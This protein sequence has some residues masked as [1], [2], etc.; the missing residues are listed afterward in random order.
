MDPV[1]LD[2][3]TADVT[4]D[5]P[6]VTFTATLSQVAQGDVTVVTDQ[7]NITILDGQTTGTLV[8][9]TQDSDVYLDASSLTATITG[10]TGPAG[11]TF[12]NLNIAT[13]TA[14]A[15][16]TDTLDLV[17]LDLSSEERREGEESSTF[18]APLNQ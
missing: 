12:E 18:K 4:E 3:S 7:G 6:S 2:L 15:N 10:A 5:D 17:T 13:P 1:T 11:V 8:I 14:T 16:I 9:N